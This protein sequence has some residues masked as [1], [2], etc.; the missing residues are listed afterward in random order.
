MSNNETR[1]KAIADSNFKCHEGLV[2]ELG[3]TAL[4]PVCLARGELVVRR[5]RSL[6][7]AL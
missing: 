3:Y 2:T 7:I 6:W 5:A 4:A 1:F